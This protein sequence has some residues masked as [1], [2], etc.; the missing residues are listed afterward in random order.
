MLSMSVKPDI[1]RTPRRS[2]LASSYNKM[3]VFLHEL[4]AE[5]RL[6][7]CGSGRTCFRVPRQPKK[8]AMSGLF[9]VSL[10]RVSGRMQPLLFD[11]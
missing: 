11:F 7:K 6:G 3:R 8:Q 10:S 1:S 4:P 2:C 5:R 9:L